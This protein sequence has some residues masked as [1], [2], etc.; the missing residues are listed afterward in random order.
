MADALRVLVLLIIAYV[1]TQ[2]ILYGSRIRGNPLGK[3][4]IAWPALVFA[5][6]AF[7]VSLLLLLYE[8]VSGRA[9]LSHAVMAL[10]ACLLIA[11]ATL[12]TFAISK[13][14]ENLRVGLPNEETA[15]VTSGVYGYSRNPIYLALFCF[16]GA[17]LTYAFS[18]INLAV[19]L[20]AVVFHHRIVLGEEKF[21]AAHFADFATYRQRVRRYL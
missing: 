18:W 6:L 4:P 15:L 1:V 21:L 16:L 8:A 11:S 9:D 17:S 20:I 7:A 14:G 12:F 19:V 13:L 5:K 2:I 3:P 10:S